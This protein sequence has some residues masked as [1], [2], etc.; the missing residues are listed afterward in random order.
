MMILEPWV[1]AAACRAE[2]RGASAGSKLYLSQEWP[3]DG[4][5]GESGV[6]FW[7]IV[8]LAFWIVGVVC[9]VVLIHGLFGFFENIKRIADTLESIHNRIKELRADDA[10]DGEEE[11]W[12]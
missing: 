12:E 9:L 10:K 4:R 7:D 6:S 1:S 11:G 3:G 2:G 5:E 8:S